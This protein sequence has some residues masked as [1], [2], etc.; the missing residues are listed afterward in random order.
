MIGRSL[1]T[2]TEKM[3]TIELAFN[4][5]VRADQAE[6]QAW[7]F[8]RSCVPPKNT[9]MIKGMR[10]KRDGSGVVFDVWEDKVE[11]FLYGPEY[12]RERD[13]KIDFDIM[14]CAALPDLIEED[15]Y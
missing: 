7:T 1:L 15:D 11:R 14:K 10:I 5:P 9:E 13:G 3:T 6:D 8:L 12:I 2:G 4:V